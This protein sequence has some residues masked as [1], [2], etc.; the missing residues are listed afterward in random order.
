M[1]SKIIKELK[2]NKKYFFTGIAILTIIFWYL[3]FF[4][5]KGESLPLGGWSYFFNILCLFIFF[6]FNSVW[7]GKILN[8]YGWEKELQTIFGLFCFLFLIA[9]GLAIPII[10]IRVTPAYLFFYLIFLTLLISIISKTR[11]S[12]PRAISLAEK[13]EQDYFQKV[14]K[15]IYV[16][17]VFLF[18]GSFFL[19]FYSRTGQFI[20]S[21]W[22]VIHPF[23]LYAWGTLIFILTILAFSRLKLKTFLILIILISFLGHAYLIIPYQTGF[24]GDKWRHL[25]AEKWLMEGQVYAPSLIGPEAEFVEIGPLKVPQVLVVGNK[26][27]Y[28]N[29]WGLVIG[30]SWLTGLDN[31]YWDLI[32][33]WLLFSIFL[34]LLLLKIGL[35][36]SSKKEFL[37][38]LLLM[39]F[40]FY[41]WQAYGSITMPVSFSFLLFVF[42]LIFVIKY[43]KQKNS[44]LKLFGALILLALFLYF[45]YLL[46]LILYLE[47]LALAFLFKNQKKN[48]KVFLPL[49]IIFSVF[50]LI[51]I[52]GLETY[53]QY[54]WLKTETD[55]KTNSQLMLKE[56]PQKLIFSQPIF[57]RI[58]GWE[59]DNWLYA[60][61]DQKLSRAVFIDILPWAL[62]LTPLVWL[63]GLGALFSY[64]KLKHPQIG[65]LFLLLL[66]LVFLNQGISYYFLE[67]N[68]LL[69]KRL[70]MFVSFLFFFPL[71]WGLYNLVLKTKRIF[72][73]SAMIIAIGLFLALLSSTVY[74]SGPK[75]QVVTADEYQA[76]EYLWEKFEDQPGPFCVLANTWPLL[77]LE[78]VS[79]RQIITGGFPYYYEYRQPERVQLFDNMN[80]NPSLRDLK[81]SLIITGAKECYFMTE[82]SWIYFARR[83][84]IIDQLNFLLGEPERIGSVMIW[85]YQP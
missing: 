33:G 41:P 71:A 39:P 37:C 72:A 51:L 61:L 24:G 23:Y 3:N 26:T 32:L 30:L 62:I 12:E 73:P 38:L 85:H 7:L 8:R 58:Y 17:G 76:A 4:A 49:I 59:Q 28:A 42:A 63:I 54:S 48:K 65:W 10:I 11:K 6:F 79:G 82:E 5:R 78:G 47:I 68:N 40:C 16:L 56:F 2:D 53:N 69:S 21:P 15:I 1:W 75:F 77:A 35:F 44:S 64:K 18:F 22:T 74:A 57:P 81:K 45:N 84:E 29:M 55:F 19:L 67:G 31:F 50:L 43:L 80:K 9:F 70:V 13:V 66:L 25:G 27:S 52:P 20:R 83:E 36:F 14:K 60:S 34:P 46:Y